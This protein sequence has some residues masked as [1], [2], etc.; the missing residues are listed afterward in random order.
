MRGHRAQRLAT[1][2]QSRSNAAA[3]P[4]FALAAHEYI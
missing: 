3:M 1:L 4:E 2:Y